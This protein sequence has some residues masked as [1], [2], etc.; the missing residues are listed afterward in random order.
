MGKTGKGALQLKPILFLAYKGSVL[1]SGEKEWNL[2]KPIRNDADL[3]LKHCE[4]WDNKYPEKTQ[5]IFFLHSPAEC[6]LLSQLLICGL[7]EFGL[8][9][10]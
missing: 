1:A 3:E 2:M 6:G 10:L 5:A 9:R 4:Y 8:P 7:S